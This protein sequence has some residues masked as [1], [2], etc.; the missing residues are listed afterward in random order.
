MNLS[1]GT[2]LR[3]S[4]MASDGR[5]SDRRSVPEGA[6]PAGGGLSGPGGS[7][8]RWH[9]GRSQAAAMFSS[10]MMLHVLFSLG[11][12]W[13]A[14]GGFLSTSRPFRLQMFHRF[15]SLRMFSCVKLL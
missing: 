8:W 1:P 6:R 4:V 13:R 10:Y 11:A 7:A 12:Q 3:Q 15:M 5:D 14:R 9:A 2:L